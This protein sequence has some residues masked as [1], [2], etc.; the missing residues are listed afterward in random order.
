MEDTNNFTPTAYIIDFAGLAKNENG[1]V[2]GD[3]FKE[4]YLLSEKTRVAVLGF[5]TY[6][7]LR[8]SLPLDTIGFLSRW[9]NDA[10]VIVNGERFPLWHKDIETERFRKVKREMRKFMKKH[11][12]SATVSVQ[13]EQGLI[14]IIASPAGYAEH[15]DKFNE[16]FE[17]LKPHDVAITVHTDTNRSSVTITKNKVGE[18]VW[19]YFE[20]LAQHFPVR[21]PTIITYSLPSFATTAD[22]L[23]VESGE[24]LLNLIREI[25]NT[26]RN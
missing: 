3:V 6:D 5:T 22:V 10:D 8:E 25:N 15:L 17:Q 4:L 23:K 19:D 20:V 14:S 26:L 2:T 18:N 13:E 9:G 1:V 11:E 12:L 7:S 16:L 24:E 21:K